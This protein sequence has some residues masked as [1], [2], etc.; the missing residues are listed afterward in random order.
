MSIKATRKIAIHPGEILQDYISD[1]KL[2]QSELARRLR[3]PTGNINEICR[4]KR[5]ISSEMALK[6]SKFFRTTPDLW[7]GLQ[8]NWE[9]SQID[10][11]I[12]DDI[13]PIKLRA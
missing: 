9:L 2:N 6:L 12:I 1:Y 13:S 11:S 4:G 5:G 10:Q 7:A 3:V 8:K